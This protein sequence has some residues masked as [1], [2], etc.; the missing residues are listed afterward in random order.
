[1]EPGI[2]AAVLYGRSFTLL[3]TQVDTANSRPSNSR[4]G[5]ARR[6]FLGAL[7]V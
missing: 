5:L 7:G 6:E 1:M 2:D 3:T 4:G